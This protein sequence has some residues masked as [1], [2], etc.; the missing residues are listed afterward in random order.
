MPS[1]KDTYSRLFEVLYK[2][3]PDM[4]VYGYRLNSRGRVIRPYLFRW[5]CHRQLLSSIRDEYG[6]GS[7]RLLIRKDRAMVFSGTIGIETPRRR[8]WR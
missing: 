1:N 3:A 7:Y 4:L 2:N 8:L 6:R 5:Y